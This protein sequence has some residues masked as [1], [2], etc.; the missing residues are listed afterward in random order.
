MVLNKEF[1]RNVLLLQFIEEQTEDICLDAVKRNGLALQF[2]KKQTQKI[3]MMAVQQNGLALQY[4][5]EQT[6]EINLAAVQQN[7][8]A[9]RW[10]NKQTPVICCEAVHQSSMAL[11]YVEEQSEELCIMAIKKCWNAISLVNTPTLHLYQIAVEAGGEKALDF[12]PKEYQGNCIKYL[13]N[14]TQPKQWKESVS[15]YQ[16]IDGLQACSN[17]RPFVY[18]ILKMFCNNS[19]TVAEANTILHDVE[20]IVPYFSEIK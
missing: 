8:L 5:K 11:Q 9:L 7:G 1:K 18:D 15:I 16:I 4:V 17:E 20:K 10:V 12:I 3:C 2:V 19:V 14:L 13:D 6:T